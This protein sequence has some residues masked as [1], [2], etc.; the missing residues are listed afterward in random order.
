MKMKTYPINILYVL[1]TTVELQSTE[2]CCDQ[3]NMLWQ[4]Y[5]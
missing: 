4:G 1:V 2:K 3:T 5:A